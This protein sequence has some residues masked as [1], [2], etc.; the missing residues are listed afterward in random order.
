[1]FKGLILAVEQL[2]DPRIRG[3]IIRAA[4][5]SAGIFVA[6]MFGVGWL[7]DGLSL[8]GIGWLD[9]ILSVLGGGIALMLGVFLYP[10]L[11]TI[12]MSFMIEDVAL[13]VEAR[14]YPGLPPPRSEKLLLVETVVAAV[15]FALVAIL[16]NLLVLIFVVPVLWLTVILAP[17]IPF[18]FYGLN[19]YL[20][21]REYFEFASFRRLTPADA[22]ALRRRNKGRIF[23]CG[24]MIAVLMTIPVVNWLMPVIAAAYMLHV[25][26]G[27][28]T[29]AEQG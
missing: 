10:S 22:T 4:M 19:G 9:S 1:M 26:E 11:T 14:H 6:L 29:R 17:L 20:L 27:V 21:G 5:I 25:F 16:L 8:I 2:G 24:L 7:L 3:V 18:V 15:R 12:V 28:R 13:A 23:L